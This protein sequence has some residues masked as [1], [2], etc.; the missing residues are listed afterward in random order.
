M[1]LLE[2]GDEG[3]LYNPQEQLIIV[4]PVTNLCNSL[5]VCVCVGL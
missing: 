4:S 3:A 1:V 2:R 5:C